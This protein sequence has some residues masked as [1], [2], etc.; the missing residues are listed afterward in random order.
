MPGPISA[1]AVLTVGEE[2][3][4]RIG[5]DRSVSVGAHLVPKTASFADR[6]DV[7]TRNQ[8][9]GRALGS[10]LSSEIKAVL[11][12]LRSGCC[13]SPSNPGWPVLDP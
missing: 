6:W 10:R 1:A 9:S 11:S 3:M 13:P 4:G 7:Y 5:T 2:S 8:A 12:L